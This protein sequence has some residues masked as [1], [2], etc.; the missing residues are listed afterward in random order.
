MK[1]ES[2]KKLLKEPSVIFDEVKHTYITKA[3]EYY[4]GCTT[5]SEAWDKSFFLGPWTA[6][7][8]AIAIKSKIVDISHALESGDNKTFESIV[9]E[10]KGAAKRKSEQAKEF[11]SEAHSW[12]EQAIM[13]K[14][15]SSIVKLPA[16]KPVEV[17]NAVKAFAGW[18]LNKD[19]KWLASEEIVCSDEHRI[20]G[21]LDAIAVVDG[22]TYLVDF[23]TS[24]QIS[25]SY[26]LQCAGYDLMLREMGLQVM[27]YMI[28][29]IPKDGTPAET[30]TITN[31]EDM[32]FFRQTFLKQRE[33]HK[34]YAYM[35]A[36][37]KDIQ[38]GKMRVDVVEPSVEI[39]K[40]AQE[41]KAEIK[42]NKKQNEN[43]KQGDKRVGSKGGKIRQSA[44][45]T[46]K[47]GR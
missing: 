39:P 25:A 4:T 46:S 31:R 1:S 11:G 26:L 6:K 42:T 24:S 28:L 21:T 8:M 14:I 29:R 45:R 18:A 35:D 38:T 20:A 33:A 41:V 36:K 16:P 5:V 2:I 22:I 44:T 17:L 13:S 47:K 32:E 40:V 7:E 19:I 34:F 12:I 10:C 43:N 9:D 15:D 37:F 23:K 30:L 27:G 3:G